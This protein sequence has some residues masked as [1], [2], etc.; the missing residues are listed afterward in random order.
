MYVEPGYGEVEGWRDEY[1]HGQKVYV[2][3]RQK[4]QDELINLLIVKT[5]VEQDFLGFQYNRAV[6]FCMIMYIFQMN[7]T[8]WR[9]M[10]LMMIIR[11]NC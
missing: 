2:D 7:V 10:E 5:K 4:S 11:F 8:T 1:E 9:Y 6:N 3:V